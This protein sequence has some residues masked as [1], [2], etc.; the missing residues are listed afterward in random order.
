MIILTLIASTSLSRAAI[1]AECSTFEAF[2][3]NTSPVIV[4]KIIII[5]II[6]HYKNEKIIMITVIIMFRFGLPLI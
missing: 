5:K 4:T 2:A 3:D 6:K 1:A